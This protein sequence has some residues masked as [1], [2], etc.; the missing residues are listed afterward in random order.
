M[1]QGDAY[2][3]EIVIQAM[4]YL[5]IG[6]ANLVNLFNPEMIVIGGGLSNLGETLLDP[7]RRGI[8]LHAFPTAAQQVRVALA[9]LGDDVGIIGAAGSAL[10][11]S[12]RR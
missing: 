4:Y 7:V 11:L 10:M 2:A 12:Q 8:A 9:Q 5:G 3:T 6:M 1:R